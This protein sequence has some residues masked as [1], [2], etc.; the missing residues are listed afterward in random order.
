MRFST[1]KFDDLDE[2][3]AALVIAARKALVRAYAPYSGLSV[4]AALRASDG[5]IIEGINIENAAYGS[6]LCA[7]RVALSA[8]YAQGRRE[9][10]A[11]AIAVSSPGGHGDQVLAPCGACRQMLQE[12][13]SVSGHSLEVIMSSADE[14]HYAIADMD[15]LLPLAA[16]IRRL[17]SARGS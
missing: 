12:A 7:E 8:A 16:G 10:E 9:F 4:G 1:L 17:S 15:D 2:R 13:A 11:L 3:Q 6:T 5:T 14:R